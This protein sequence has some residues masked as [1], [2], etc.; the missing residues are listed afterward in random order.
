M[1]LLTKIRS[2]VRQKLKSA[3]FPAAHRDRA[4]DMVVRAIVHFR[5]YRNRS[6][7]R[8]QAILASRHRSNM[9]PQKRGPKD[10]TLLRMYLLSQLHLAWMIA[11]KEYPKINNK[12]Y[13]DTPF[14]VFAE[15][16]LLTERVFRIR[17]N[18]ED[19]R[20]YRRHQL[21]SSGFKV[22]RGKVK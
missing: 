18:L 21:E 8:A 10:E 1:A 19:F 12:H 17:G 2:E 7:L 3:K 11:F 16:I 14:V 9:K 22:S 6:Q 13:A 15:S 4:E 5:L 20:S